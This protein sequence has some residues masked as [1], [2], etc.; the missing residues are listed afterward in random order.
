LKLEEYELGEQLPPDQLLVKNEFSLISP[1]TELALYTGTHT[2]IHN[3]DIPFAKYPF[4]PGYASVGVIERAGSEAE[5]S[6]Y[7]PGDR[8]YSISKHAGYNRVSVS[9]QRDN[10]PVIRL[11]SGLSAQ[12]AVFA[13]LAAISMTSVYQA[14]AETGD[15]VAIF[16]MGLV[17]NLAAQLFSLRGAV[18]VCIDVEP[19]RLEMARE[20]GLE[21]RL[22]SGAEVKVKVKEAIRE[23][24]GAEPAIVVEATGVPALVGEALDLVK[25]RGQVI[26]LGSPRGTAEIKVYEHIHC[27]GVSLIGAHEMV[28]S[29]PGVPN[30]SKTTAYVMDLISKG[31]LR[32]KPLITHHLPY[33]QADAAYDMLLNRKNEALGVLLDW[34]DS[35]ITQ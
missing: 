1:G 9:G 19:R 2:G 30:R 3:P 31:L 18:P 10:K 32:I 28:Q 6:G 7:S 22:L 20:A 14:K 26:L 21:H 23:R 33:E 16:G 4:Y 13:R 35:S 5:A 24:F 15:I 11:P 27:K 8:V 25:A 12:E 34:R 17:G 29:M